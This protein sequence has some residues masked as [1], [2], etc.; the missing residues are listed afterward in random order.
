[1]MAIKSDPLPIDVAPDGVL[2]V[3]GSRVTVDS[4]YAAFQEGA[5]AEEIQLRYDSIPLADIYAVIAY[6]LRHSDEVA[7]YLQRRQATA[8]VSREEV[9]RRQWVQQSRA[10][11][12][13][14]QQG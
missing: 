4:I 9:E 2:R 7:E 6:C 10:R 11:L 3:A 13:S 8:K 1:M 5:S 12:M 14:R